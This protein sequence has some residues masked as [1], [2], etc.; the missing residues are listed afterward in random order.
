[1]ERSA[2]ADRSMRDGDRFEAQSPDC[3]DIAYDDAVQKGVYACLTQAM[4]LHPG[5]E[6]LAHG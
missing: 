5:Y 6:R 1:M 2:Q 4:R 3:A